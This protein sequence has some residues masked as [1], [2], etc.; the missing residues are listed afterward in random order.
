MPLYS[1]SHTDLN[2]QT[3]QHIQLGQGRRREPF[4]QSTLFCLEC[5]ASRTFGW[6]AGGRAEFAAAGGAVRHWRR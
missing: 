3:G 5:P 4:R 6:A 2:H 1:I